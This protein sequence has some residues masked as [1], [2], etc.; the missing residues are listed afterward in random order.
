M[1]PRT[2]RVIF[3][4]SLGCILEASELKGPVKIAS[5]STEIDKWAEGGD[6]KV[7]LHTVAGLLT[8]GAAGALGAA[9]AAKAAPILEQLQTGIAQGLKDAGLSDTAAQGIAQTVAGLTAAGVGAAVGGAG[10]AASALTIDANN[11]QLHQVERTLAAQLVAKS[12]G[13]FTAQQVEEQMRLMGNVAYGELPNTITVLTNLPA[14][15]NSITQ[16]PGLP[17]ATDG[18]TVIEVAGQANT[19]IQ[20]Y[21]IANSKEVAGTIPGVSPYVVSNV[22][23]NLPITSN[24]ASQAGNVTAACAN[25]DIACRSGVGVQQSVPILPAQQQ[26]AGQY[27]GNMSTQYQRM[28][29]LAT[30]SGNAPVVLS[31]EI[32]SGVTAILEQAFTPSAGKVVVDAAVLDVAADAFSRRSGIP[33]AI[34]FE[35]VE[36]EIKPRLESVRVKIDGAVG[37]KK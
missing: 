5:I 16:D 14:I 32:A 27:F 31:F 9:A 15:S 17:K 3:N 13:K 23:L 7:A 35:V 33:R 20:R 26:A 21:I 1:N 28:A 36:R 29:V 30:A 25:L 37:V 6:H 19:D 11:R 12:G 18:K 22:N 4:K 2:H 10:G 8:G 34:V 24:A